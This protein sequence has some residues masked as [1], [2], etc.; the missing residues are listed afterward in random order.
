[1]RHF[2]VF[3]IYKCSVVLRNIAGHLVLSLYG[4][5]MALYDVTKQYVLLHLSYRYSC[6]D[7]ISATC[8]ESI[9]VLT[10]CLSWRF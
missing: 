3:H 10:T 6:I 8:H 2:L 4:S 5:V 9:S 1:M 7:D